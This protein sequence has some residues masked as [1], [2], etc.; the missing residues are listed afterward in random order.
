MLKLAP[1]AVQ[2]ADAWWGSYS[3]WT[4]MPSMV[5]CLGLTAFIAWTSWRLLE[6]G[7]VQLSVLTLAGALWLV[8]A[9][10]WCYR[11]FG[12][13]YRVTTRRI[14]QTKGI[15]YDRVAVNLADITEVEV[16]RG[17]H[18]RLAGV[19]EVRLTVEDPTSVKPGGARVILE[20]V[21]HPGQVADHIRRLSEQARE[22][23]VTTAKL[24]DSFSAA[25]STA[26]SSP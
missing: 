18:E 20:G 9:F 25:P 22:Q 24:Q 2:E 15:L 10:R 17:P 1:E 6:K 11:V 23:Q 26:D 13:N 7:W 16:G 21:S 12:Y 4:M 14:F 19:G 8:Q 5:V 3:G